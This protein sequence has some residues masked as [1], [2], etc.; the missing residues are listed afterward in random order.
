M[1]IWGDQKGARMLW[2]GKRYE[3]VINRGCGYMLEGKK[4]EEV[5]D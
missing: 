3:G 1:P 2:W 5:I 4:A